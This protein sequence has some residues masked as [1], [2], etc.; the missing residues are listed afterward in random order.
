VQEVLWP[1][2][3]AQQRQKKKG[4]PQKT[5]T[6]ERFARGACHTWA[7]ALAKSC[8]RQ[9]GDAR[10]RMS[11]ACSA[12]QGCI[13][14]DGDGRKPSAGPA[15]Q[16]P[17]SSEASGPTG[18][19]HSFGQRPCFIARVEDTLQESCTKGLRG[20]RG[21]NRSCPAATVGTG[22]CGRSR[23]AGHGCLKRVTRALAMR[24]DLP[25][26]HD[27]PRRQVAIELCIRVKDQSSR[28]DRGEARR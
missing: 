12:W 21:G 2:R 19:Q 26:A 15:V 17:N 13:S 5:D 9:N 28:R 18:G 8:S 10:R 16:P 6:R 14:A 23:T 25:V 7:I 20:A 3:Q 4:V 22:A 27:A 24:M 1:R 11:S